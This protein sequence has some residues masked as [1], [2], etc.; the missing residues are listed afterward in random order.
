LTVAV[1]K[2]LKRIAVGYTEIPDPGLKDFIHNP[3][4]EVRG[5]AAGCLYM[6][7]P[8]TTREII[9]TWLDAPSAE[10]RHSGVIAAGETEDPVF[11]SKLEEMLAQDGNKGLLADILRALAKIGRPGLNTLALPYLDH[12]ET[13]VRRAAL[14]I[15][16]IRDEALLKRA[17]NHLGDS[18]ETIVELAKDKIKSAPYLNGQ[19]LIEALSRPNRRLRESVFELLENLDIKD[20]DLIRFTRQSLERAYTSLA[21]IAA[22][23][24]LPE[25]RE[26]GLLTEHL[27]QKKN[28]LLENMLRVLAIHYKDGRMRT[29]FRGLFSSNSRHRANSVELLNDIMDKK[30]FN[31]FAPL[32]EGDDLS[33]TLAAGKK[34]FKLPPFE[35]D[36]K[37]LFAAMLLDP[38]W[39]EVVL[40]L[41]VLARHPGAAVSHASL[42]RGLKSSSVQH[43]RQMAIYVENKDLPRL[44]PKEQIMDSELGVSEKIL[45][46]KNIAIFS[47]LTVSELSAI[48]TVTEEVAYPEGATVIT[49]GEPGETVFLI[50]AGEVAVCKGHEQNKEIKLDTMSNGDYFGEMA[51]FEETGRSASIRTQKPSR[52]LVLHKQEFNE[53]VREYPG[54]AL[55]ICTVL[56]HRLRHLHEK[57][58]RAEGI[59]DSGMTDQCK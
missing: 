30:M 4:P 38:D 51:L 54:I 5:Q 53:L 41:C 6:R 59:P 42:I 24:K 20:L 39:L 36:Q 27:Y 50:I 28:L 1:L 44:D 17:I 45:L 34:F 23:E 40:A 12:P 14:E 47:G 21:K 16:E 31:M 49:E 13:R 22:L 26:K 18:E 19:T 43:I 11:T 15:I 37:Q 8:E 3:H 56:S 58:A 52:F 9:H 55:Q 2:T 33:R 7:E 57:I 29:V 25:S 10:H 48:A 46:L 35:S 32:L